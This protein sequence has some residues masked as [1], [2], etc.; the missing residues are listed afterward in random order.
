LVRAA[1]AASVA[2]REVRP[3]AVSAALG[4]NDREF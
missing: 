3:A 4:R 2:P 1:I